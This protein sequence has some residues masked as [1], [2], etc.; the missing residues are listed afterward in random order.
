MQAEVYTNPMAWEYCDCSHKSS[1]AG[2]LFCAKTAISRKTRDLK[3]ETHAARW[4]LL[5]G[6]S[7]KATKWVDFVVSDS[8]R[9]ESSHT[10]SLVRN[11]D[12]V[13]HKWWKCHTT[14]GVSLVSTPP[15]P[16]PSRLARRSQ[17]QILP[18]SYVS[19]LASILSSTAWSI[20]HP[21]PGLAEA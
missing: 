2:D 7:G 16:S 17:P 1:L 8:T 20:S 15:S 5:R 14:I 6:Y 18:S 10:S 21:R 4:G 19:M 9:R 13:K 11:W 12:G 3:E